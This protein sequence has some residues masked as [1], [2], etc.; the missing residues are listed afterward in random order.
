M[1][2][3]KFIDLKGNK[4]GRLTVINRVANKGGSAI[5]RCLCECGNNKDVIGKNLRTGGTK[6]C[7]CIRIEMAGARLRTHGLRKSPSYTSWACMKGRCQNKNDWDY[8]Y[9]GGRGITVC[10]RWQSFEEF[11]SDMGERPEGLTIERIDNNKGYFPENCKWATRSEQTR[12][13]RKHTKTGIVGVHQVKGKYRWVATIGCGGKRAYLGTFSDFF[14]ACCT[15]K[16]AEISH[17]YPNHE[18]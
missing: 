11:Y 1:S 2:G 14:E 12:N 6:S 8:S 16:S 10:D 18:A 15:R 4:Y 3:N 13:A 9:Y 7:G 17:N 5:W